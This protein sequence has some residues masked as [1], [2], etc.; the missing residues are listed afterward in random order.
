MRRSSETGL[1][2]AIATL[3]AL[4][5][6]AFAAA[7]PFFTSVDEYMHVD[8]V[9][10][11]AR[12]YVPRPVSD[13]YEPQMA[14]LFG[15][16]G[17]PE[18]HM[19]E[20]VRA[21]RGV[22]PPG[23]Q[24]TPKDLEEQIA[25][26]RG[27]FGR[28]RNLEA[29]QPP[30]YYAAA[31][32]WWRL[33]GALGLR[34]G[35]R[36]YWLRALNALL[37]AGLVLACHGFLRGEYPNSALIRL[38]VPALLAAFPQDALYYVT[39]DAASPLLF[40]GAFF[41]GVRLFRRPGRSAAAYAA[42]GTAAALAVLAKYTNVAV[43]APLAA[44]SVWLLWRRPEARR[45]RGVGGKLLVAWLLIAVPLAVWG[46]RNER[47]FGDPTATS[48]KLERMRWQRKAPAELADHPLLRA[49]G[50]RDFASHLLPAFW[51]GELPWHRATLAVPAVD[52]FYTISSLILVALAGAG[53]VR[54]R[55]PGRSRLAEASALA[56]LA[57][58]AGMLALLSLLFEFPRLGNPSAAFPYF[59]QGR[60][61][62]GAVAPFA[63]L[64]LR[65]AMLAVR[66]LPTA[67][68]APLAWGL[69][70]AV[71]GVALLSEIAL[72]ARVFASEYNWYHLP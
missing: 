18:Y 9:L 20:R 43:L 14:I 61:V 65:G 55:D 38:G 69:L 13:D 53:L 45:L 1:A 48:A 10:K 19:R 46:L 49:G 23:W 39:P 31:A 57:A 54:R 24:L 32:L 41:L 28:L 44:G 36:L 27:T 33:G 62:S 30:V 58:C 4:R 63:L 67:A 52:G 2:V 59:V 72:S 60:L 51:R 22:D 8:A 3:A 50:V 34:G 6:L 16:Y 68:R 12:G 11:Y 26:M 25:A 40:G 5:V 64:Y 47:L 7:F 66:P 56:A 42:T 17:T 29:Y 15:T 21:A 70:A 35:E 71:I 37:Y